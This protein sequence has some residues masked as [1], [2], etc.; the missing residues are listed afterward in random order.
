MSPLRTYPQGVTCW[1]DLES[2][3]VQATSAF[4]AE[5]FGWTVSEVTPSGYQVAQLNRCCP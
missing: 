2:G 3:D 5:L 1:V 4:Y